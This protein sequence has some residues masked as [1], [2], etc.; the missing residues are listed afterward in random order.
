[1]RIKKYFLAICVAGVG[2][3]QALS[4]SDDT[5][6]QAEAR[7]LM[8]AKVA[9]LNAARGIANP[10]Q[11]NLDLTAQ[12]KPMESQQKAASQQVDQEIARARAKQNAPAEPAATPDD[13]EKAYQQKLADFNAQRAEQQKA[14]AIP[15]QTPPSKAA[16]AEPKIVVVTSDDKPAGVSQEEQARIK[17]MQDAAEAAM[18]KKM[19]ELNAAEA[20]MKNAQAAA[21]AE[22]EAK[23]AAEK[24]AKLAAEAEAKLAAE[25]EAKKAAE[26]KASE[27]AAKKAAEAEAKNAADAKAVE[28]ATQ[29][30]A[31]IEAK[32]AAEAKASEAKAA[33]VA[34]K[35]DI[36]AANPAPAK[37]S[38][39][40]AVATPTAPAL[41][42][43]E[44]KLADL[45]KR[46]RADQLTPHEYQLERA[47]ILSDTKD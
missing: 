33:A 8:E 27:A 38:A 3:C 22:A 47:K 21:K 13:V 26:A 43:R 20:E 29:R 12:K 32:R 35:P 28:A 24:A 17:A 6:A 45:L 16:A 10:T 34:A 37:P 44:E 31:E 2:I 5:P 4:Q 42:S 41:T 14:A 39:A 11:T 36:K 40:S 15:A 23:M 7:R 30:A 19:A 46:Y 9:D 25:A 18:L 1:M